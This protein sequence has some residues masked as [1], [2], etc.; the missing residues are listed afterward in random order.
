LRG[1]LSWTSHVKHGSEEFGD[2]FK[3]AR[4]QLISEAKIMEKEF[5]TDQSS[6]FFNATG[7]SL[8]KALASIL[9]LPLSMTG[10]SDIFVGHGLFSI[11]STSAYSV[12]YRNILPFRR[13][14]IYPLP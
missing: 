13:E 6:P 11:R 10:S 2:P 9:S 4:L 3:A 1:N 8:T 12:S 5:Q 7:K 14:Q